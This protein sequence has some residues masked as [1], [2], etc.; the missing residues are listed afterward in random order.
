MTYLLN[1]FSY[2]FSRIEINHSLPW[3]FMIIANSRSIGSL[4]TQRKFKILKKMIL[5]AK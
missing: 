4:D 1:Y 5:H 2:N 3:I